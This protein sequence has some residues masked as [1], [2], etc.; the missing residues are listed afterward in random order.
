MWCT[1]RICCT[2]CA[3]GSLLDGLV[4]PL[5]LDDVRSTHKVPTW[6]PSSSK[7]SYSKAWCGS[8]STA[9]LRQHGEPR[10]ERWQNHKEATRNAAAQKMTRGR[11]RFGLSWFTSVHHHT[12]GVGSSLDTAA[13]TRFGY[14]ST[15][16]RFL[17]HLDTLISHLSPRISMVYLYHV[18]QFS[19]SRELSFVIACHESEHRFVFRP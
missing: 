17:F 12:A 9:G 7:T 4:S 11:T 2:C 13:K 10:Q 8:G 5:N 6:S 14:S 1:S 16:S 19:D 15:V 18:W 3:T